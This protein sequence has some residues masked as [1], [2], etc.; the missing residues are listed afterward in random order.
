[1]RLAAN[2]RNAI[3]KGTLKWMLALHIFT[4]LS[5][6]NQTKTWKWTFGMLFIEEI[7][8]AWYC[9]SVWMCVFGPTN[10]S[11]KFNHVGFHGPFNYGGIPQIWECCSEGPVQ[12]QVCKMLLHQHLMHPVGCCYEMH[13]LE[14]DSSWLI[15]S[16]RSRDNLS[17]VLS[18]KKHILW[19]WTYQQ[20]NIS[21][22]YSLSME[23][24]TVTNRC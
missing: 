13:V 20:S 4:N 18:I 12:L 9:I 14:T 6:E 2:C 7:L 16:G 8:N 11:C 17:F 10:S 15:S 23:N 21:I 22:A 5:P 24:T 3:N 1:M 19:K